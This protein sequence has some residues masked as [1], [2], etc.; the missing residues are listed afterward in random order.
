MIK[1][2]HIYISIKPSHKQ[3][4]S[5]SEEKKHVRPGYMVG[6]FVESDNNVKEEQ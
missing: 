6:S 4:G 2:I 1:Y 3:K 5:L